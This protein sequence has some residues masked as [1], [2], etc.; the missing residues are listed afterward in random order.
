[1]VMPEISILPHEGEE[2]EVLGT[3]WES[4][5]GYIDSA[6]GSR[7]EPAPTRI[8]LGT[9]G[10]GRLRVRSPLL[11]LLTT[12]NQDYIAG[13]R[14]TGPFLPRAP[15]GVQAVQPWR[16]CLVESQDG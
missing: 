6:P 2:E 16:E 1:M 11:V 5:G 15:N 8:L 12:E 4:L 14:V 9:L 3:P 7:L 10:D 13:R